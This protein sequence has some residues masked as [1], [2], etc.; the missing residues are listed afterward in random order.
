MW[1]EAE[2]TRVLR[3]FYLPYHLHPHHYLWPFNWDPTSCLLPHHHKHLKQS[4]CAYIMSPQFI[5][6]LTHGPETNA[7]AIGPRMWIKNVY[8]DCQTKPW[9]VNWG[10]ACF[11][12]SRTAYSER[13]L[14]KCGWVFNT[15]GVAYSR[16]G[17]VHM[18]LSFYVVYQ[19]L[20]RPAQVATSV[21]LGLSTQTLEHTGDVAPFLTWVA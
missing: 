4:S 5:T 13:K 14:L 11:E 17:S 9:L 10:K 1:L 7:T 3:I 15:A 19:S 21:S 6:L 20:T 2:F 12:H 16:L 18:I 8:H